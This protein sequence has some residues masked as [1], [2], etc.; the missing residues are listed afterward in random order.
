M[1]KLGIVYF[2]GAGPG[3]PDLITRRGENLLRKADCVIY[4]RLVDPRLLRLVSARCERVYVGKSSDE[5]G[6]SQ[7]R[8]NRLLAGKARRHRIVIRLKGG[9]PTLFG[10]ISEEMESLIRSGVSFE[11]VPGVSSAWAAAGLAGIPLTDR[12]YSSSVAIAT[13]QEAEG[14]SSVRW[15]A[16]SR[17]ADTLVILMGRRSLPKIV[18][19]LLKAG[20]AVSTPAALIHSAATPAQKILVSRLG[21]LEK[22][23][24]EHPEFEPPVVTVIGEVVGLSE[25][26]RSRPLQ[27]KRIL[28]TRPAGDGA[29]FARRLQEMGAACVHLP[30]IA[31]RPRRIPK[32]EA[33]EILK[34]LPGVDWILFTSHHGVETLDRLARVSGVRLNRL[35]RGKV[36]AIGPRTAESVR[37]A[38]LKVDLMPESFSTEGI[39]Q[40]FKRLPL[41][42]KRILIPRS[43]LGA[44]DRLAGELRRRGARV[45]E[46]VLYETVSLSIPPRR[47][48]Q[49]LSGIDAVTFTS[50]ST[51]KSFLK[52]LSEAKLSPRSAFNGAAVVAIGPATAQAL[53]EGG[54]KRFHLPKG[55][56]TVEGLLEAVEE[57]VCPSTGSGRTGKR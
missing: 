18:K 24:K 5:G 16:L 17:G 56:W 43:N 26:F 57:A 11:I 12:R 13:G 53:R 45:A 54:I 47:V 49:A 6:Q 10:R 46:A 28:V 34:R 38:G 25:R 52:A 1:S 21:D 35:V 23:L 33:R 42:G 44:G 36:C 37:Q 51:V 55:S 32:A 4:D 48:K 20:K 9:D 27:G 39:R 19:R 15:E 14:K 3:D 41:R 31:V 7:S 22:D 30:T 50:A 29:S 40:T 2:V 8:I